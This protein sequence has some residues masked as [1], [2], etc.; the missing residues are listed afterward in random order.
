MKT[1][2]LTFVAEA[3]LALCDD[4]P[5]T[6]LIDHPGTQKIPDMD[7][8][9]MLYCTLCGARPFDA[10]LAHEIQEVRERAS[11][12]PRQSEVL[13]MRLEGRT[14]EDIGRLRR[15]TKQAAQNIFVQALKKF[16]RALAVYEY[17]GLAEVY[18]NEINRGRRRGTGKMNR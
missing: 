8:S 9:G 14:F 17:T 18:Q 3:L 16:A 13:E 12:T 1:E 11:L 6:H 5:K 4:P 10:L 2:D 7:E 15:H